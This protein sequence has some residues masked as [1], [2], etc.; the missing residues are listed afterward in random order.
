MISR[1]CTQFQVSLS[2]APLHGFNFASLTIHFEWF[3]LFWLCSILIYNFFLI[4]SSRLCYVI[5]ICFS[6]FILL[7]VLCHSLTFTTWF[8]FEIHLETPISIICVLLH[9]YWVVNYYLI[10]LFRKKK[11]YDI[12]S[13]WYKLWC[14]QCV[15]YHKI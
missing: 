13:I 4:F 7:A 2:H 3:S 10:A 12:I 6:N 15:H 14:V 5:L 11:N 1:I 8:G 9:E